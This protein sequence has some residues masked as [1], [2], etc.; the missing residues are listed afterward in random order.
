M[1][2]PSAPAYPVAVIPLAPLLLPVP[3]LLVVLLVVLVG[4]VTLVQET[5]EGTEKVCASVRSAHWME[6]EDSVTT[7]Y[8]MW[9]IRKQPE[10]LTGRG[11]RHLHYKRFELS[12]WHHLKRC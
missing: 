7:T 5:L 12:R 2:T 11:Y 6:N 10:Y 9:R 3:L 8:D 4:E 1:R